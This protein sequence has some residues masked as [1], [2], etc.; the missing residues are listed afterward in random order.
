MTLPPPCAQINDDSVGRSVKE[1]VRLVKAF[2]FADSH[3]G[4]ACPAN[5]EPGS[6]TIKTSH[7]AKTEFFKRA[8]GSE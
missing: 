3:E 7:E 2:Q 5:W 4:E 8:F 6:D 1:T